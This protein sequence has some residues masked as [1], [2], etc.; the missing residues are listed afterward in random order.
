MPTVSVSAAPVHYDVAGEGPELVLVHGTGGDSLTNFSHLVG[1]F[2]DRRTVITPDYAG[3]GGT[4]LPEGELTLDLLVDQVAATFDGPADLVGFSLGA[5]V[6]AAVAAKHPERIRSLVLIAGWAHGDDDPRLR[7]GLSFWAK[8]LESG[9]FAG[10]ASLLAF[11]PAFMRGWGE[12]GLAQVLTADPPAGTARQIALDLKVDI[13]DRLPLI[14]APTLV[15]GNTQDYLVPVE[16]SRELHRLIPGSRYAELD[17]GHVV[18]L[19][20]PVELTELIR[21]F[22]G[23]P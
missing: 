18:V 16:H 14:T 19:E 3:S 1:G 15:I 5:V 4:P 7:L 22:I 10:T 13:R 6:A 11:S 20:R 17:S 2:A 8:S 23:T 21:E 9:D 12:E